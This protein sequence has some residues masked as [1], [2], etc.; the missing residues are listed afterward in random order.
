MSP[1]CARVHKHLDAYLDGELEP[2][3][4]LLVSGHLLSCAGCQD[5]LDRL[6]EI[7]DLLRVQVSRHED[8]RDMSGLASG[9]VSRVRAEESQSWT[10]WL[11]EGV[12][13]WRW[14]MIAAGSLSAAMVSVVIAATVCALSTEP[15]RED[16][17]AAMLNN[18][19]VPAGRLLVIATP[20]G[21]DQAPI[22]MQFDSGATD[23]EYSVP[24]SMPE[25]MSVPTEAELAALLSEAVIGP[26][27]RMTNLAAMSKQNREQTE[28]LLSE[29]QRQRTVPPGA[30][31]SGR[32]NV[33]RLCSHEHRRR[34]KAR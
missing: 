4:R 26:D 33:Q 2:R 23:S 6:R 31:W 27:G 19:Q 30:S 22:L 3:R 16:S 12:A 20:V 28:P 34:P 7:G 18:L 29:M 15:E 17:L 14:P 11:R 8:H 13:D 1:I 25:G 21:S 5:R 10:G 24:E 32:Q 9:V